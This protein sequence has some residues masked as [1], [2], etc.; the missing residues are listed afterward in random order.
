MWAR[1]LLVSA[2]QIFT[3]EGSDERTALPSAE[4]RTVRI[5]WL[6]LWKLSCCFSVRRC[7]TRTVPLVPTAS[8]W[9]S[10]LNAND[11]HA[12][13]RVHVGG[14][15]VVWRTTCNLFLPLR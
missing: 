12:N 15:S 11:I 9:P 3:P 6:L 7:Q 2:S 1:C 4:K 5:G 13:G 10:G 8:R 14:P